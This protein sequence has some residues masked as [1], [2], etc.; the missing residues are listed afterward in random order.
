MPLLVSMR[1]V[2][3]RTSTDAKARPAPEEGGREAAPLCVGQK[4]QQ[5]VAGLG[6]L[7]GGGDERLAVIP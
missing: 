2:A 7:A 5:V 3:T 6:C 1:L 4:G